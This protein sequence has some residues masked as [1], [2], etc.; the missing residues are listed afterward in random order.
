MPFVT[1]YH[2]IKLQM[3]TIEI[4]IPYTS[5]KFKYHAISTRDK[6]QYYIIAQHPTCVDKRSVNVKQPYYTNSD[7]AKCSDTKRLGLT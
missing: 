7:R 6:V 4:A 5:F 3:K 1:V 2:L